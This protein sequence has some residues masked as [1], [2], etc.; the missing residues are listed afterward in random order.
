MKNVILTTPV[1]GISKGIVSDTNFVE[2]PPNTAEDAVNLTV[3]P[4]GVVAR[5][6]GFNTDKAL[7]T[8]INSVSVDAA[9]FWEPAPGARKL[10]EVRSGIVYVDGAALTSVQGALSITPNRTLVTAFTKEVPTGALPVASTR[11]EFFSK[12]EIDTSAI[13]NSLVTGP[14]AVIS[15]TYKFA[16][17]A[18]SYIMKVT[19]TYPAPAPALPVG[20]VDRSSLYQFAA[21]KNFL[22][23]TGAWNTPTVLWL[24]K[25]GAVRFQT[26]QVKYREYAD[27]P[28]GVD[29]NEQPLAS[30]V[31][32]QLEANLLNRGWTTADLASYK[33]ATGTMWPSKAMVPWKGKNATGVFT[34]ADLNKIYFNTSSAPTGSLLKAVEVEK[35]TNPSATCAYG[36]RIWYS[37]F[38]GVEMGQY[39]AYTQLVSSSSF[40]GEDCG[41]CY[42]YNDP[43]GEF[44]NQPTAI[45][46]GM[47]KIEGAKD[48]NRLVPFKDGVVVFA[49]NGVWAITGF[50]GQVFQ[51]NAFNLYKITD[52]GCITGGGCVVAN[53]MLLYV[54][55]RGINAIAA[56]DQSR[57]LAASSIT[58]GVIGDYLVALFSTIPKGITSIEALPVVRSRTINSVCVNAVHDDV[59][60]KVYFLIGAGSAKIATSTSYPAV[61]YSAGPFDYKAIIELDIKNSG[62]FRHEINNSGAQKLGYACRGW[63]RELVLF[64][65]SL[66]LRLTAGAGTGA[67][68]FKDI[69]DYTI[70]GGGLLS[71]V[72]RGDFTSSCT[73]STKNT[74]VDPDKQVAAV[75][76]TFEN[77]N[78]GTYPSNVD[79]SCKMKVIY[80][81]HS[82][83]NSLRTSPEQEAYRH[84]PGR[85]PNYATGD[86]YRTVQTRLKLRGHGKHFRMML[87]STGAQ[88]FKLAGYSLDI[89]YPYAELK[90]ISTGAGGEDK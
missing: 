17:G 67:T 7:A 38:C 21:S 59:D 84:V 73:I 61:I 15:T 35:S 75:N 30:V 33:A 3:A 32:A 4:D 85:E 78:Y 26:F 14:P 49:S 48:I 89:S 63:D 46:G 40:M 76:F 69:T 53:D 11:S 8:A 60:N 44:L 68:S 5:R 25:D 86:V 72:T 70:D 47:I 50:N 54:T 88:N 74:L 79:G 65:G 2:Y 28:D 66:P 51:G 1:R 82:G 41:K 52:E 19:Y 12:A 22:V 45:D 18:D 31:N 39:V 55:S 27:V 23:I 9:Y 43:T 13:T 16:S 62:F 34:P 37:G 6:A 10:V 77:S 87:K 71:A 24:S 83:I 57:S 90:R 42:A 20:M 80:D 58:E 64:R 81:N 29:V 56:N 36:S